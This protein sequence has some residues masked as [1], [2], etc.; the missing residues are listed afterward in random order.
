M[1]QENVEIKISATDTATP[2][3]ETVQ[4]KVEDVGQSVDQ[5]LKPKD[6]VVL[7]EETAN[8]IVANLDKIAESSQRTAEGSNDSTTTM[9]RGWNSWLE[10]TDRL[11]EKV[12]Q[13]RITMVTVSAI[14]AASFMSIFESLPSVVLAPLTKVAS[15]VSNVF[16]GMNTTVWGIFEKLPAGA[17]APLEVIKFLFV[18]VNT[19]IFNQVYALT[20]TIFSYMAGNT[21]QA[22]RY[23][24]QILSNFNEITIKGISVFARLTAVAINSVGFVA[25]NIYKIV[26]ISTAQII[27][28]PAA[29]IN[30]LGEIRNNPA[31]VKFAET[32]TERITF[33]IYNSMKSLQSLVSQFVSNLASSLPSVTTHFSSVVESVTK[34]ASSIGRFVTET[35]GLKTVSVAL[36]NLNIGLLL[37]DF[38][39]AALETGVKVK[40]LV[41]TLG[42][43]NKE[44]LKLSDTS[45]QI[46]LGKEK[47]EAIKGSAT[48]L[49]RTIEESTNKFN[50]FYNVVGNNLTI[51]ESTKVFVDYEKTLANLKTTQQESAASNA[52]MN[53]AFTTGTTNITE[54]AQIFGSSLYPA[55]DAVAKQTGT[56]KDKLVALITTG[57]LGSE[58]IIPALAAAAANLTGKLDSMRKA[59][60]FSHDEFRRLALA[61]Q[62]ISNKM[63]PGMAAALGKGEE[64]IT[65]YD[66]AM[67]RL[68]NSWFEIKET[69]S[70]FLQPIINAW[71]AVKN[72]T[73]E[74]MDYYSSGSWADLLAE[75]IEGVS[76]LFMGLNVI[77]EGVNQSFRVVG[78]TIGNTFGAIFSWNF[79]E[80]S[81]TI[82]KTFDDA[83]NAIRG[84]VDKA[85]SFIAA[86]DGVDESTVRFDE[87]GKALK[88]TIEDLPVTKVTDEFSDAVLKINDTVKTSD[89]LGDVWAELEKMNP[90]NGKD[91][92]TLKLALAIKD[93]SLQTNDAIGTQ[94]EFAKK[95]AA[96]P[97]DKLVAIYN[98]AVK[99]KSELTSLGDNGALMQT[100]MTAAFMKLGLDISAYSNGLSES[101]KTAVSSFSLIAVS[102]TS[103]G[104]QIR[105]AFEKAVDKAKTQ[106]DLDAIIAAFNSSGAAGKLSAEEIAVAYDKL[107]DKQKKIVDST[108]IVAESFKNLGVKT[109]ADFERLA[110]SSKTAFDVIGKGSRDIEAVRKAFLEMAQAEID[111]AA[112]SGRVVDSSLEAK[113]ATLGLT[114]SLKDLIASRK[115][116]NTEV[117]A[118]I[119]NLNREKARKEELNKVIQSGLDLRIDEAEAAEIEAAALGKVPAL[120]KSIIDQRKNELTEAR[121]LVEES[122]Q[123]VEA[124]QKEIDALERLKIRGQELTPV[125]QQHLEQLKLE[126]ISQLNAAE[127]TVFH[128]K[129]LE[130][131]QNSTEEVNQSIKDVIKAAT[132]KYD[133][134]LDLLDS[135]G[136]VI[137]SNKKVAEA[138]GD[139][140]VAHYYESQAAQNTADRLRIKAKAAHDAYDAAVLYKNSLIEQANADG[141]VTAAE[142]EGINAATNKI[143]ALYA[144]ASAADATSTASLRLANALKNAKDSREGNTK[145][146]KEGEKTGQTTRQWMSG[147]RDI[148]ATVAGAINTIRGEMEKLSPQAK[149]FYDMQFAHLLSQH[150]IAGAY[151]AS[152]LASQA[153]TKAQER[154]T[155]KTGE[156]AANVAQSIQVQNRLRVT[157][158]NSVNE[159]AYVMDSMLMAQAKTRQIFYEQKLEL[160]QVENQIS[161][162]GESGSGA[163]NNLNSALYGLNHQ[164]AIAKSQFSLLNDADLERLQSQIDQTKDKLQEMA[165]EVIDAKNEI[166][167][168]NAD[169]L[170]EQGKNKEAELLRNKIDLEERLQ[171]IS[172][173]KKESE[174]QGNKE[175]SKAYDIQLD[176]IKELYDLKERNIKT[177]DNNDPF[178][179]TTKSAER[180]TVAIKDLE[181]ATSKVKQGLGELNNASL[182]D[183]QNSFERVNNKQITDLISNIERA[184]KTA[185]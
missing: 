135:Q 122:K 44:F 170:D 118:T 69:G 157:M 119:A 137:D 28:F 167:R 71:D 114:E 30:A 121:L 136:K 23:V 81:S 99:V 98:S 66:K 107:Q 6:N 65:A 17:K 89:A 5:N 87:T 61:G 92:N 151:D 26:S 156:Y 36:A 182:S 2:I 59:T 104:L 46:D 11:I 27:Q 20:R 70:E 126:R 164:A 83:A 179:K 47:F 147:V 91:Q 143:T 15:L 130:Y 34:A 52:A 9:I 7:S 106:A 176:K 78:E 174:L 108:S 163:F 19:F 145:A 162:L 57:R 185:L 168:L 172:D 54:L 124:T 88:K 1:S 39:K 73:D 152:R 150:N 103:T 155:E 31:M 90:F 184:K 82:S 120:I 166:Q 35:I 14:L 42:G 144:E 160:E 18:D 58:E 110:Q 129:S 51:K 25:S 131:Q 56:T 80:L 55:L 123:K 141:V 140:A 116:H 12:I 149:A 77:F 97:D 146:D 63:M 16:S 93:V 41:F 32:W 43:A 10:L 138:S 75:P 158:T 181:G 125:Q 148:A 8:R 183:L 64:S 171:E 133:K 4:T 105:E 84:T 117:D 48:T 3:L 74:V 142:Q 29:V 53:N 159:L 37:A 96:L 45:R 127:T 178:E 165:D 21:Q 86:V 132:K 60:G 154:L 22:Q 169:I 128:A 109:A 134:D 33:P 49:G 79:S 101:G 115:A 111:A 139:V 102:A 95:L 50:A 72:K 177:E 62:D 113:A 68:S 38:G 173:K 100:I 180:A 175:A 76:K 13:F 24:T 85:N 161:K 94:E 112:A 40:D 67:N 153:Y